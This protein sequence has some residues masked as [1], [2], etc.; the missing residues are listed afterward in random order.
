MLF[1]RKVATKHTPPS[2]FWSYNMREKS[3]RSLVNSC[4]IYF[5]FLLCLIYWLSKHIC[6]TRLET[7]MTRIFSQ[8]ATSLYWKQH[9]LCKR[10]LRW[11][12]SLLQSS[13]F[14]GQIS[15]VYPLSN[16]FKCLV[17]GAKSADIASNTKCFLGGWCTLSMVGL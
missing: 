9:S 1:T 17:M 8:N 7:T 3:H 12:V 10:S 5:N 4:I 6:K 16:L 15:P 2:F 11:L 13:F 14:I